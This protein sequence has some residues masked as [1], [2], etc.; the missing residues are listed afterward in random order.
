MKVLLVCLGNICRSPLAEGILRKK[1]EEL[2][3]AWTIDSAGTNGYHTG[4][5]PHPLSCKVAKLHGIDISGQASRK[6]QVADWHRFDLIIAMSNDVIRD[7]QRL[8]GKAYQP[9]K[10]RLILDYLYPG[11]QRDVPDPWYGE[12]PDYHQVYDLLDRACNQLLASIKPC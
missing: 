5:S 1:T 11:E 6:F 2:G 8:S 3:L 9:E 10:A 12:E 7:M 4:E